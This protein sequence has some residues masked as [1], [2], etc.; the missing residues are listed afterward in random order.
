VRHA[1]E[2]D[3]PDGEEHEVVHHHEERLQDEGA[4]QGQGGLEIGCDQ[5]GDEPREAG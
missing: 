3:P 2:Q 5:G 4:A 1:P